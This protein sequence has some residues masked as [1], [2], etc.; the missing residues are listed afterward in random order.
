MGWAFLAIVLALM[1]LTSLVSSFS[2]K[3]PAISEKRNS[4]YEILLEQET[5]MRS[6]ADK[7]G[8]LSNSAQSDDLRQQSS[9]ALTESISNL[10]DKSKTDP[11]AARWYAA[12]RT[13]QGKSVP[14]ENIAVLRRSKSDRD[15][16][17]YEVYSAKTLTKSEAESLVKRIGK[18][19]FYGK[20]ATTQAL[21]KAGDK[22]IRGQT[23][24]WK[25]GVGR[26]IAGVMGLAIFAASGVVWMIF[27]RGKASGKFRPL[28]FPAAAPF[29]LA[30]ADRLAQRAVE[31]LFIFIV[32]QVLC[33]IF[34]RGP[35]GTVIQGLGILA[36]LPIMAKRPIRGKLLTTQGVG[37]NKE[38]LGENILWGVA[39]FLAELPLSLLFAAIGLALFSFLPVPTHPVEQQL[40]NAKTLWQFAPIIMF[41]SIT[42]PIWEEF[43]F[44][45]LIFPSLS[46]VTGKVPLAA[47]MTGFIFAMIH[48]QGISL[49]FALASV[50]T[51]GCALTYQRRS[52]VPTIV[53]H[54]LH[55]TAI[56]A[57]MILW[58]GKF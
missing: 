2:G 6:M 4:P 32:L 24:S 26:S 39:G 11:E 22:T 31:I 33:L 8:Q 17:I 57:V 45:G 50:G 44:R 49:W 58:T 20:L 29:T 46:R 13:E 43:V 18:T 36:A 52:L 34:I 51:M 27:L 5:S 19:D 1:C 35:L 16:A 12:M 25:L 15:K 54:M 14:I 9:E 37:L 38:N 56:F 28:G 23:F 55:N 10:V 41:G 48:P 53:M 3:K 21:E 42:A 47:I 30:N 7:V 40:E